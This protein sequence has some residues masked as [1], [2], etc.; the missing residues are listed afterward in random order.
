MSSFPVTSEGRAALVEELQHRLGVEGPRLVERLQQ[1]IADDPNLVENSGYHTAKAE[2]DWNDA[3][4]VELEEKIARVEV[5]DPAKL[6]GEVIRFGA[7]V[8][9]IDEDEGYKRIWQIVGEPEADATKGKISV[10]SPTARALLGKG[11]GDVVEINAPGG[12][13]SYKVLKVEWV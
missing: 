6:S 2:Q 3:R 12:I 8:T 13:K 1:A 4:I 11:K 9:L 5:V 7:K 10:A